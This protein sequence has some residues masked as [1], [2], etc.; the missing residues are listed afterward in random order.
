VLAGGTSKV[1]IAVYAALGVVLVLLGLEALRA[2]GS[3]EAEGAAEGGQGGV[4]VTEGPVGGGGGAPGDVVV[5]VAGAVHDPGVYRLAAGARVADAI[6]RAGGPE[7][8]AEQNAINL[9]A[10]LA[11][12][13]Q[14]VV[15]EQGPAGAP[16]AAVG[17][18][19]GPISLGTA[20]VEDLET[21]D[22]IGPVTAEDIVE[23]RDSQGG[24][25][26]IEDLDAI[27][28]IGPA[29]IESLSERLQP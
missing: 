23:F 16:T 27:P 20:T 1:Q 7:D 26:S 14:V 3:G 11:D 22:G 24:V 13:Q 4:Q 9:A 15:P 28:G 6:E 10:M 18:A 2:P 17:A 5:H 8:D 19:E 21:I 25:G 29:T 12:G